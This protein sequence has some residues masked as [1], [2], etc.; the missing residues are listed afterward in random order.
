MPTLLELDVVLQLCVMIL[1]FGIAWGL[2]RGRIDKLAARFEDNMK[3]FTGE[4]AELVK[5]IDQGHNRIDSHDSRLMKIE[6]A[7]PFHDMRLKDAVEF[8]RSEV[9]GVRGLIEQHMNRIDG[10]FDAF[11]ERF[12]ALGNKIDTLYREELTGK[13][14][15]ESMGAKP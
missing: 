9:S 7:C 2:L 15:E 4:L 5:S 13:R 11:D 14:N 8:F 1:T 12:D 6:T 3:A 10:R